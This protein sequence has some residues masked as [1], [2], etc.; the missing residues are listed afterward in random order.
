M[1]EELKLH[2]KKLQKRATFSLIA[3]FL[4]FVSTGLGILFLI[5]PSMTAI[6]F[7][8]IA[9]V[10]IVYL[11]HS[12]CSAK[13]EAKENVYVPV[14]FDTVKNIT[15]EEVV[16]IFENITD[17][18]NQLSTSKDV[19]FFRL[20]KFFKLRTVIYKTNIFI[21]KEFDS[22]KSSIN[23]KANKEL[24]I[25]QW[26]SCD[27]ARKM[28]RFNII[29]ADMINDELYLLLSQ[30]ANRNLSRV[31]GIINISIVGNQI[32]IPPLYGECDFAEINRYKHTIKFIN[33]IIL[34]NNLN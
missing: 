28:M 1:N 17:K 5:V 32:I 14:I 10:C 6:I 13:K 2:I 24:N 18:E 34:N 16:S 21:K 4:T 23:K 22:A 33:Q 8:I 30:N 3:I 7:L 31:E 12:S 9:A 25:S 26:V 27:K 19:R 29:C 11:I 20:N 15:F